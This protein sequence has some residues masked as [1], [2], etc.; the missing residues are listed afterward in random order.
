MAAA[1][2]HCC[3]SVAAHALSIRCFKLLWHPS[4]TAF[5]F[6]DLRFKILYMKHEN[7]VSNWE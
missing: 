1:H 4:I 7:C 2:C 6:L 3:S 5:Q